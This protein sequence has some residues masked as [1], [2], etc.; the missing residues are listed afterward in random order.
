[1]YKM[2]SFT[3]IFAV[4]GNCYTDG[5]SDQFYSIGCSLSPT[6]KQMPGSHERG[7][8]RKGGGEGGRALVFDAGLGGEREERKTEDAQTPVQARGGSARLMGSP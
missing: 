8:F 6:E 1:M 7:L 5:N 3:V 4:C 2:Y